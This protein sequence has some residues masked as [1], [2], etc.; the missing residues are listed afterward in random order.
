MFGIGQMQAFLLAVFCSATI[1]CGGSTPCG[2]R[3][4]LDGSPLAG[5]SLMFN[6]QFNGGVQASG[7]S[8]KDGLFTL[9]TITGERSI[10][11]GEYAVLVTKKEQVAGTPS[12]E[13]PA[14]GSNNEL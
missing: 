1:G 3:V 7:L 6:P 13:V 10:S 5:A 12:T 4:T 11:P 14:P 2:G 9:V 8:D